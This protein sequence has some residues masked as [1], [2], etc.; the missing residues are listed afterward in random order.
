MFW[1]AA[2]PDVRKDVFL[3]SAGKARAYRNTV[4]S[5]W[6]LG[7]APLDPARLAVAYEC[8]EAAA[9]NG[10][11]RREGMI[12]KIYAMDAIRT[13]L[14]SGNVAWAFELVKK[15][16]SMKGF[17]RQFAAYS[18]LTKAIHAVNGGVVT[19]PDATSPFETMFDIIRYPTDSIRDRSPR[20]AAF[21][22]AAM[23]QERLYMERHFI[24][25]ELALMKDRY[26]HGHSTPNLERLIQYISE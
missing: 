20:A 10:F 5:Q 2:G 1:D 15:K 19:D 18:R 4:Y 17:D 9:Q 6:L 16:R 14:I 12:C 22:T 8:F 11:E 24:S 25:L 7:K 21:I 13:A 26:I 23:G 3:T